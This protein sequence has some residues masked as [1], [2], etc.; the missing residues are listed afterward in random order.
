ML[1]RGGAVTEGPLANGA[2]YRPTLIEVEPL[3]AFLVQNELFGPVQTFELFDDEADAIH[4]ANATEFGLA[5]SIFTADTYRARRMA[6]LIEAGTIWMN[7]WGVVT[8]HM[9]ES[10][11]KQSGVGVLYGPRAIEQFQEIKVYVSVDP[12]QAA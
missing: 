1:V 2:F 10:G 3:D 11:L 8:E 6:R 5:A 4:R 12:V 9:E 7:C